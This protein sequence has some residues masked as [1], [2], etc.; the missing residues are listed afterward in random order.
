MQGPPQTFSTLHHP[1]LKKS[2]K[3]NQKWKKYKKFV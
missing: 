1:F 3:K 2:E